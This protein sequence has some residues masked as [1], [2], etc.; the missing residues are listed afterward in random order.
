MSNATHHNTTD[1]YLAIRTDFY[2]WY[3]S[4]DDS[5]KN[6]YDRSD[7][8]MDYF[9][10]TL[11]DSEKHALVSRFG[12]VYLLSE[13]PTIAKKHCYHTYDDFLEEYGITDA[14]HGILMHIVNK[15]VIP[16]LEHAD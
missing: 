6:F 7:W 1:I 12:I 10:N 14:Y 3:D 9:A 2:N 13:L 11:T 15:C 16:E 4:V 5:K 8:F